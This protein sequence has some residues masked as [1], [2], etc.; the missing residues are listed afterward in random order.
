LGMLAR[1]TGIRGLAACPAIDLAR[2]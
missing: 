2:V 1:L